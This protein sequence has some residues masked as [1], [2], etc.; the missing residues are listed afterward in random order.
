MRTSEAIGAELPDGAVLTADGGYFSEENVET[1]E[2]PPPEPDT[3][4][5]APATRLPGA[6]VNHAGA[7][8]I[9]V[10]CRSWFVD[11]QPV[12]A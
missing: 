12:D 6:T 5:P 3:S 9:A 7:R 1:C 2:Q 10:R 11:H 4:R 8:A